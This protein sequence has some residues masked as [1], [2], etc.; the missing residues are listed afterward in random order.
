MTKLE[1]YNIYLALSTTS[2]LHLNKGYNSIRM[3]WPL[4]KWTSGPLIENYESIS[5]HIEL[6]NYL[7]DI[8]MKEG[9]LKDY[10]DSRYIHR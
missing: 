8:P 9:K 1:A 10:L 5:Y 2:V 3:L 6:L 7:P 4:N